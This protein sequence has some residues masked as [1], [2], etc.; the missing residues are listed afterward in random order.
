MSFRWPPGRPWL[1]LFGSAFQLAASAAQRGADPPR[2][3]TADSVAPAD[4]G[5]RREG[6]GE[7]A[8]LRRIGPDDLAQVS[9]PFRR[10][11][12][13]A[14]GALVRRAEGHS[15]AHELLGYVRCE[16][17]GIDRRALL[18][19]E[20]A[21]SGDDFLDGGQAELER[22]RRLEERLLRL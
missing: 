21:Q 5:L 15:P 12:A 11:A 17:R 19:R 3:R 1:G 20:K 10:F 13:P 8:E 2:R 9:F 14:G 22:V 7:R 18:L 4:G 16:R 6:L